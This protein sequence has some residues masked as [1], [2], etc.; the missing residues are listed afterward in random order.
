MPIWFVAGMA[1][2]VGGGLYGYLWSETDL[3]NEVKE[4]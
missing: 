3:L 4:N 2:I 1:V